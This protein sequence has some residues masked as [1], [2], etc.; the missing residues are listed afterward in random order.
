MKLAMT[1]AAL[2]AAATLALPLASFGRTP[3]FRVPDFS[4]LRARAAET[5]ERNAVAMAQLIEDL[6]DVSRIISG[7]MRLQLGRV[8]LVAVAHR[9]RCPFERKA[10]I[11]AGV[12]EPQ[13]L[14]PKI[15]ARRLGR[16][17]GDERLT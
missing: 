2:A 3:E 8:D 12:G 5:I 7:K 11:G 15:A 14:L 1:A 4:H 13:D 6:L 17:T 9:Q 16:A 10:S